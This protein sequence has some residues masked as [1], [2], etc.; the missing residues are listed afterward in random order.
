MSD[1]FK[2]YT[3]LC[4]LE[5][6]TCRLVNFY[7]HHGSSGAFWLCCCVSKNATWAHLGERG[8]GRGSQSWRW[9]RVR[10]RW[11]T[12][13][14]RGLVG[15]GW[16]EE[17]GGMLAVRTAVRLFCSWINEWK[18]VTWSA[19]VG[20]SLCSAGARAGG[21]LSDCLWNETE[22]GSRAPLHYSARVPRGREKREEREREREREEEEGTA[23]WKKLA[24]KKKK[25]AQC[26]LSRR[27]YR[28]WEH[29]SI[30]AATSPVRLLLSTGRRCSC[31]GHV[32]S[33]EG[34]DNERSRRRRRRRRSRR[35]RRGRSSG[36]QVGYASAVKQLIPVISR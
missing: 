5:Q 14:S 16:A 20:L 30:R 32:W 34:A 12:G 23:G 11:G 33:E 31:R 18:A 10:E 9:Q 8:G 1:I 21:S 29:T 27:W 4:R 15:W 25:A 22:N 19:R 36:Q 35:G 26:H 28:R 17:E 7:H 2:H 6:A 24:R 3:S 13:R